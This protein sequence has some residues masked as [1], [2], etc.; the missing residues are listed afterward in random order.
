MAIYLVA[1]TTPKISTSFL[2]LSSWPLIFCAWYW[3][4]CNRPTYSSSKATP[5]ALNQNILLPCL[6]MSMHKLQRPGLCSWATHTERVGYCTGAVILSILV[7]SFRSSL[8][9]GSR[10]VQKRQKLC[11]VT[12]PIP[13]HITCFISTICKAPPISAIS[14]KNS[15]RIQQR[16][17]PYPVPQCRELMT[18]APSQKNFRK[19]ISYANC[20]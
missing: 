12:S 14:P 4:R 7:S 18:S 17:N 9:S 11:P 1:S 13:D 16:F 20:A 10:S 3:Y 19:R 6:S 2:L 15:I 8:P 5:V